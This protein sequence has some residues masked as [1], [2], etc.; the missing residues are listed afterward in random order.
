MYTVLKKF[1]L[2]EERQVYPFVDMMHM[3]ESRGAWSTD[4]IHLLPAWYTSV[5][6]YLLQL[7]C[8]DYL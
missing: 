7:F 8:N 3:S 1:F 4:G 5:T 2:G 6:S